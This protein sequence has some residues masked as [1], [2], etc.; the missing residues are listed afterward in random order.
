MEQSKMKAQV[1]IAS[2]IQ[3]LSSRTVGMDRAVISPD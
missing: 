2:Q 3:V 1:K